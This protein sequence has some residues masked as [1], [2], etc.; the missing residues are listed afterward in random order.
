MGQSKLRLLVILLGALIVLGNISSGCS[1]KNPEHQKNDRLLIALSACDKNNARSIALISSVL[2]EAEKNNMSIEWRY[3]GGS[4]TKQ[5]EDIKKLLELMPQYLI[6]VPARS[7]GLGEAIKEANQQGTKVILLD[8]QVNDVTENE[9]LCRISTD[10]EWEGIASARIIG[11]F[12]N[13]KKAKVLEI[14]GK[15]GTSVSKER[16]SGFRKELC[17]Y[18]NLEIAGVVYGDF[19]RTVTQQNIRKFIEAGKEFDAIFAHSDE[20]GLGALEVLRKLWDDE[21][22]IPIVS[23]NGQQDV[24]KAL[25]ANKYYACVESTPYLGNH[26]IHVIQNDMCGARISREIIVEGKVVTRDNVSELMGY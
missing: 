24:K 21:I 22:R 3:A 14:Q 17:N 19:D 16:S 15:K 23:V 12:F 11:E 4:F 2:E 25:I 1:K 9:Y 26:V 8:G 6:I 18:P 7:L 20:E 13:G 5:K 10:P